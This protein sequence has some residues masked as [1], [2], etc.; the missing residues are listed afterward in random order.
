MTRGVV[1]LLQIGHKNRNDPKVDMTLDETIEAVKDLFVTAGEVCRH[2]SA[3]RYPH[4]PSI[5]HSHIDIILN[6][7]NK[8]REITVGDAVEI[9]VITKDGVRTLK[10]DLKKD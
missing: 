7:P 9:V 1:E 5:I 10:F 3:S 6:D 8:Q 4:P 2:P